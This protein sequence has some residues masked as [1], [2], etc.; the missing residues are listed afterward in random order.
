MGH[1]RVS[2]VVQNGQTKRWLVGQSEAKGV[3]LGAFC[4]LTAKPCADVCQVGEVKEE[5]LPVG[6]PLVLDD[7]VLLMDGLQQSRSEGLEVGDGLRRG[8][9]AAA[10]LLQEHLLD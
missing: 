10:L 5:A 1:H 3:Q 9:Q 6:V 7:Q 8:W 4:N 2:T